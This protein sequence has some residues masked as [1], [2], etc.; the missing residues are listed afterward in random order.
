MATKKGKSPLRNVQRGVGNA[1]SSLKSIST[2]LEQQSEALKQIQENSAVVQDSRSSGGQQLI[3]LK[4]MQTQLELQKDANENLKKIVSNSNKQIDALAKSNKDWKGFSDKFKDLK[5][6]LKESIDPDNI[7]KA[8]LGPFKMFKGV[9]DKMEDMDYVKRMRMMGDTRSKKDLREAAKDSRMKKED[10]LRTNDQYERMKKAG[11]TD[12]EIRKSN[13]DFWNKRL[14]QLNAY[15]NS[16]L[17]QTGKPST[18]SGKFSGDQPSAKLALLPSDKGQVAQSTTDILAEKTS[19]AEDQA[20]QL[21]NIVAQTDLLQQIANNTA[22]MAGKK[23]LAESNDGNDDGKTK[24]FDGLKSSLGKIGS[25]IAGVGK[26]VGLAIGGI[27]SGIMTGIADGIAAFGT[28]KVLKGIVGMGLI[29]VVIYGFS[30]AFDEFARV[31]WDQV[32]KGAL[33]AGL[34][35]GAIVTLLGNMGGLKAAGMATAALLGVSLGIYTLG[36]AFQE[37][38]EAFTT[39]TDQIE[40]LSNIGF[41]GLMGTAGGILALA[42]AIGAFGAGT[43]A[44]GLGTLIGNLLTIGQD[45]PLEQLQKLAEIGPNLQQAADGINSLGVA[46][47][48][49]TGIDKKSM[50][51][52]ND[53][54]WLRATAFV[55]AGGAMSIN[56]AKIYNQSKGNA[57]EQAKVEAKQ[58][59]PVA[60]SN[61]ANI[62]QN[63]NQTNV[64]RPPVRNSE[65]SYNKYLM[66]RF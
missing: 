29:G 41:E 14:N 54:P 37:V 17:A 38:G 25:S 45:S 35:V 6:N 30:K 64:V 11:A 5:Q 47:K 4:I 56:G 2:V 50:D 20:E 58:S 9:R 18:P 53:F 62:Q 21:R 46:M 7:K 12:D 13:P 61:T 51:A 19:T 44:A 55:A 27:F 26:G 59:T 31:D 52:I 48:S 39:F 57:D 49:F 42:G 33:I 22:I 1:N 34:V 63:N 8:I 60:S 28:G 40:R 23:P 15:N 36:K 24:A 65:S 32:A 43:A 66:N 10:V 16:R 3:A